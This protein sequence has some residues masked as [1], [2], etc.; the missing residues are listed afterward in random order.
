MPKGFET[1]KFSQSEEPSEKEAL[2]KEEIIFISEKT[3]VPENL[4][5]LGWG[6]QAWVRILKEGD[7]YLV[8]VD[9]DFQ[10]GIDP[11]DLLPTSVPCSTEEEAR[12]KAQ[13]ALSDLE[14]WDKAHL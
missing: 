6:D 2:E 14:A 8:S 7:K 11:L 13:E 9:A 10:A 5:K 4:K 12:Q 3:D 1:S